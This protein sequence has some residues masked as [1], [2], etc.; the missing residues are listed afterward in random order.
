MENATP[1]LDGLIALELEGGLLHESFGWLVDL[2]EAAAALIDLFA[3]VILLI[4]AGRFIIGVIVAELV[5]RGPERVRKT[6]RERIELGRYILAGLDL[7]IVSDVIHT[8]LSLRFVDL[9]FLLLL[10]IIRSITSYFLDRELE[11][12]KQELG[13]D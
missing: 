1:T 12:I 5:R 2:L 9:M 10:V 7:F 3:I 4:G 8:A 11:Q 6:D 13:R